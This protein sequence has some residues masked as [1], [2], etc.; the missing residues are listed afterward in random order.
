MNIFGLDIGFDNIINFGT[1]LL[2]GGDKD[3]DAGILGNIIG[4]ED[5]GFL[6]IA[7]SGLQAY[8]KISQ[9]GKAGEGEET[10]T[11]IRQPSIRRFERPM[12][13]GAGQAQGS[14]LLQNPR[15]RQALRNLAS[16]TQSSSLLDYNLDKSFRTSINQRQGRKTLGLESPRITRKTAPIKAAEVSKRD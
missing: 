9:A 14:P 16:R 2:F 15:V 7:K 1:D 5:S 11:T 12:Y 6:G 4:D 10:E 13:S 3:D 8:S